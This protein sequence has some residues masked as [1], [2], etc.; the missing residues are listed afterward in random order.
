MEMHTSY[1]ESEFPYHFCK[2]VVYHLHNVGDLYKIIR[3]GS[4]IGV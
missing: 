1:T 4:E 2:R 3:Y